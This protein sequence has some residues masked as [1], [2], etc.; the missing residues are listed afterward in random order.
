MTE[1]NCLLIR[2][3]SSLQR[4]L[5]IGDERLTGVK[6]QCELN[7]IIGFNKYVNIPKDKMHD[8]EEGIIHYDICQVLLKFHNDRS[9]PFNINILN[10][11]MK[12]FDFGPNVKN[13]PDVIT[14]SNLKNNHLQMTA[15]ESKVL[16]DNIPFLIG[17]LVNKSCEEWDLILLLKEINQIISKNYFVP[18]DPDVVEYLVMC[19]HELYVKCFGTTLKPKHHN[20][21]HYKRNM[22]MFGPMKHYS[23]MRFESY[24]QNLKAANMDSKVN[25]LI[26]L[27]KKNQIR[28]SNALF[29]SHI[30]KDSFLGK[31]KLT[32]KCDLI[33]SYKN[34]D[35]HDLPDSL[36][37]YRSFKK[38]GKEI[39]L[40]T[41]VCVG[42]D[43]NEIPILVE[44]QIFFEL[45]NNFF[46]VGKS[47]IYQKYS[48]FLRAIRI[49][50]SDFCILPLQN[51][52][53]DEISSVA[54]AQ[55]NQFYVNWR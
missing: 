37:V 12:R 39:H 10:E 52:A 44:A 26:S 22:N 51:I 13:V 19:H 50:Y 16:L 17:D 14:L 6:E 2:T 38:N 27:S 53:V 47:L 5:E 45:N 32:K 3:P 15:S 40:K 1:E 49:T 33:Q 25:L 42:Y 9:N 20:L 31:P 21:L 4:E 28:E 55:D 11:R 23:S 30:L 41:V 24:H 36:M 43:D 18:S 7:K 35:F 29:S 54:V 34:V 48:F 8:I 46:M